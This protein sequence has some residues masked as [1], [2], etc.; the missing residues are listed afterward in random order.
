MCRLVKA[1]CVLSEQL[2]IRAVG[3]C[4]WTNGLSDKQ[5]FRPVGHVLDCWARHLI[6]I[7]QVNIKFN[8]HPSEST[9]YV[10]V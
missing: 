6:A 9:S 10:K 1:V 5:A 3:M 4:C 2:A 7:H 8:Q